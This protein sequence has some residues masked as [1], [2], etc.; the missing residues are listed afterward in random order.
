[1]Y[2]V[3]HVDEKWFNMYR[4]STTYYL[5][6]METIPYRACPN[7]RYIG[8]VMFLAAV[9]RPRY[10]TKRNIYF[11]GKIGVWPVVELVQAA[12]SSHNRP[13]GTWETKSVSM[14][15]AKYVELL[16]KKVFPAIRKKWPGTQHLFLLWAISVISEINCLH[17]A[18]L[19]VLQS[20][21]A[22]RFS[23]SKI[24]QARTAQPPVKQCRKQGSLAAGTSV[25]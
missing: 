21:K 17:F 14:N 13:A 20:D 24:T 16:I 8:K 22:V 9:A 23:Y 10:D 3:V 5:S 1:M 2:D 6:P 11:D 15:N 19:F 18:F 7:K 12:R 25:W 4:A